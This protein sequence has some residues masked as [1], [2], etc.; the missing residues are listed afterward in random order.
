LNTYQG[1]QFSTFKAAI[2]SVLKAIGFKSDQHTTYL[3]SALSLFFSSTEQV[4][5]LDW[6]KCLHI[7]TTVILLLIN[8]LLDSRLQNNFRSKQLLIVLHVWL[9]HKRLISISKAPENK[10]L[11]LKVQVVP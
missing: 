3:G 7:G 1:T 4:G 10:S 2:R 8:R 9:L 6:L 11:A 5:K